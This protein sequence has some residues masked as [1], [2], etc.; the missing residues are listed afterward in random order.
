[1]NAF[2][3]DG[4]FLEKFKKMQESTRKEPST[5]AEASSNGTPTNPGVSIKLDKTAR[6][7]ESALSRTRVANV[8]GDE[9]DSEEDNSGEPKAKEKKG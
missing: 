5:V 2:V 4:S 9:S 1:M 8:F 7:T 6:K 3:N